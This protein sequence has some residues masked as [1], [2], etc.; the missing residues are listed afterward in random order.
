VT[1]TGSGNAKNQERRDRGERGEPHF[2]GKQILI[3]AMRRPEVS[4]RS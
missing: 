2:A 3:S 4:E 1:R